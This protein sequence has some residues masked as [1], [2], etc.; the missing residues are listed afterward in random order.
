MWVEQLTGCPMRAKTGVM[1]YP[2]NRA[3]RRKL[4]L[5]RPWLGLVSL[6]AFLLVWEITKRLSGLPSFIL[7]TPV[8]VWSRFLRALADGSLAA[9]AFVTL[10]E[11][12]SGLLVGSSL[13]LVL[14]YLIAKSRLL[15]HLLSPFLVASQAV[16]LVA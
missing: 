7:P 16:P 13:A 15:D 12:L 8:E 9:N 3:I 4:P 6:V 10:I 2:R 5:L 14:G 1:I 11:V